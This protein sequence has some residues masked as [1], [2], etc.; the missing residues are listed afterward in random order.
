M[1]TSKL[2]AIALGTALLS[3]CA[4]GNNAGDNKDLRQYSGPVKVQSNDQ[5]A[6]DLTEG[7]HIV[8]IKTLQNGP[9]V[10]LEDFTKATGYNGAWLRDGSY[11]VGDNDPEWTFHT[12]ESHAMLAGDRIQLSAP[13]IKEGSSL[14]VP[15]DA[16][17]PLFGDVTVFAVET[18]QVAFF[19]KPTPHETGAQGTDLDFS[20]DPAVKPTAAKPNGAGE[21]VLPAIAESERDDMIKFAKKFMGVKYEFGA[22]AYDKSGTFDCST[23]VRHVYDEY[24]MDLPRLARQQAKEGKHIN[25]DQLRP[26]DLLFFYVP[27][28]F[29]SNETVGHVGMYYGN[30]K[31]IHASPKPE[32]G[33]QLTDINK[34]YWKETFLYAKR[35]I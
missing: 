2:L 18:E 11:G 29:K 19:P 34:P 28:R 7:R 17:K 31:M 35:L 1:R 16:L 23:F 20:D 21:G 33:V 4:N 8:P 13:A 9:Y 30:G 15:V 27:G 14:Y 3:G 26:G 12:G 10:S 25:R 24:G 32:D 5:S 6:A 22:S